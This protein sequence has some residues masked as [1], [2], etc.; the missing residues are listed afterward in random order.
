MTIRNK[1]NLKH[2]PI[3]ASS[4][5]YRMRTMYN[6]VFHMMY[7]CFEND[8]QPPIFLDKNLISPFL[9]YGVDSKSI[10]SCQ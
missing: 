1:A 8:I 7:I 10:I 2:F 3:E 4:P 9:A 5:I 6:K